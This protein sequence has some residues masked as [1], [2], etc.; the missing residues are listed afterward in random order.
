MTYIKKAKSILERE[1]WIYATFSGIVVLYIFYSYLSQEPTPFPEIYIKTVYI[2]ATITLSLS[3][4]IYFFYLVIKKEKRPLERFKLVLKTPFSNPLESLNLLIIL[5][6]ISVIFSIYTTIKL[7][8]P[9]NIFFYLDPY[10]INLDRTIHFGID[11]WKITHYLFSSPLFSAVIN[12]FYNLWFFVCWIFLVVFSCLYNMKEL[13]NTTL[14]SFLLCWIINGSISATLLSSVGPCF[15][16][17]LYEGSHQFSE[18]MQILNQQNMYL[19]KEG[20]FLGVWSLNTQNMLWE[21]YISQ[22]SEFGSGISAMPSMHVSMATLMALATYSLKKW[23]GLVFWLYMIIIMIG[24]VHLGW[25]YALDGYVGALMTTG[26]WFSV[27]K[28]S[29]KRYNSTRS[30]D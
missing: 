22:S 27:A 29:K 16:D 26:I 24:S 2:A 6:L 7:A 17:L 15:Y 8:I 5:S 10:L 12:L 19:E 11:P 1:K 14:I 3:S 4:I 20:Y 30:L 25:H 13:R 21:S 28:L 9:K 23:I 18:L